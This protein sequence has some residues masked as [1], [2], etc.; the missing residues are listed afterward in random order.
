MNPILLRALMMLPTLKKL[1]PKVRTLMD[2]SGNAEQVETGKQIS[3]LVKEIPDDAV[4]ASIIRRSDA[5]KMSN[6]SDLLPQISSKRSLEEFFTAWHYLQLSAIFGSYAADAYCETL[7]TQLKIFL[8]R[9]KVQLLSVTFEGFIVALTV[10]T[11][12]IKPKEVNAK[13]S[14][15]FQVLSQLTT[16]QSGMDLNAGKMKML[17]PQNMMKGVSEPNYF[18]SKATEAEK[19]NQGYFESFLGM[20]DWFEEKTA[21]ALKTLS[22]WL[23]NEDISQTVDFTAIDNSANQYLFNPGNDDDLLTSFDY[24]FFTV[25]KIKFK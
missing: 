8:E 23:A 24:L 18:F 9:N 13:M 2:T 1:L 19:E 14:V 22:T 17:T 3:D 12:Q 21:S 15:S 20:F 25:L 4:L 10:F 5:F 7:P 11:N 6:R 16:A